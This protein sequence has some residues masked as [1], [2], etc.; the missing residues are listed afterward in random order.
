MIADSVPSQSPSLIVSQTKVFPWEVAQPH[1]QPSTNETK[2]VDKYPTSLSL[3]RTIL[4]HIQV[5]PNMT[6]PQLALVAASALA[7]LESAFLL[8]LGS[9]PSLTSPSWYHFLA[10]NTSP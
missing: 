9:A 8:S 10:P 7:H 1:R 4:R 5:V 6:E 3:G 2:S